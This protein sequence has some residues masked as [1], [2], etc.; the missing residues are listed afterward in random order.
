MGGRT[1]QVVVTATG[2]TGP[3]C[4]PLRQRDRKG[5]QIRKDAGGRDGR[6]GL[7]LADTEFALVNVRVKM[8]RRVTREIHA[9]D[10]QRQQQHSE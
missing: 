8:R 10:C 7:G 2:C 3:L 9:A 4:G 5:A 1:L 6:L